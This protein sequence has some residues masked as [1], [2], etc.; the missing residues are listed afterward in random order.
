MHRLF[1]KVQE[2]RTVTETL[3]GCAHWLVV[4]EIF[5]FFLLKIDFAFSKNVQ[6]QKERT[7]YGH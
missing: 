6:N 4:A 1:Q 5:V 2:L 3:E 7:G